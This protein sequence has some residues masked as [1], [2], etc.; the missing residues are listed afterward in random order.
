MASGDRLGVRAAT[1]FDSEQKL[2]SGNWTVIKTYEGDC[3]CAW[4]SADQDQWVVEELS[5]DAFEGYQTW[6]DFRVVTSNGGGKGVMIDDLYVIGNE[7]RNNLDITDVSTERYA[8]SGGEHDLSVTV[9]GI[10]LEPQTSVTVTAVMTDSNGLRV[11]P[12]DHSFNYFTLP[13]ALEKGETFTID[14]TTGGSDWTWGS[15]L[16]PGIY[17]MRITAWR[18]DEQQV[19][20]ENPANNIKTVTIVLGAALLTDRKSVV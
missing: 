20:D 2:S 17:Q 14:P 4:S 12:A 3:G 8:A 6:I 11:W 16:S 7:Y 18:D 10:G 15:G 19:H 9:K 5:L 13:I 1:D